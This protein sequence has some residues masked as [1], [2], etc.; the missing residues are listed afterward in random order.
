MKQSEVN[1]MFVEAT[2]SLANDKS[3]ARSDVQIEAE[4]KSNKLALVIILA[5]GVFYLV[6]IREGH[7]WGDDFSMYIQHAKNIAEGA[8]Y[9]LT[10][11]IYCPPYIGPDSY[12]PVYPLLLAPVV[13]LLGMNLTAMKVELVLLF[14]LALFVMVQLVRNYIPVNWQIALIAL[15]GLN[16]YFWE[17]KD[18]IKSEIPFFVAAYLSIYLVHKSYDA[19]EAGATNW[20][21]LGY[22]LATGAAFYLAYGTRSIGLI[23]LPCLGLYDL[24]RKRKFGLPSAYA[25]GVV[26]LTI[27]MI[28]VQYFLLRS[29]RAYVELVQ[30]ESQSFLRDWMRFILMNIPRYATSMTQIWD[31][32]YSK[33]LRVGLTLVMYGLAA[34]GFWAQFRKKVTFIELFVTLYT[35]FVLIIPMDGGVRYLLP[36]VPFYMFYSL[37]G[38]RALPQHRGFR[39][40]AFAAVT[41]AVLVTYVS[42]YTT[43]NFKE[44]PNGITKQEAVEFFDYI[45]RQTGENDVVIFTKP[46][47][48][49]LYTGRKSSYYPGLLGDKGIWD[50][51]QRIKATH[52][53]L[54]PAGVEPQDQVFLSEF[55]SKYRNCVREEYSNG[56]FSVYR[57][58]ALPSPE[59]LSNSEAR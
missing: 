18:H 58:T 41:A 39:N 56:A 20:V 51:F 30:A 17:Y 44:I 35:V 43:Y 7:Y 16:P 22:V 37:Q 40:A 25:V 9:N 12:P 53:V 38:L 45:K 5:I 3:E 6:T 47:A 13:G 52:I 34:I 23:L 14:M 11:Y 10:S 57:I 55:L 59:Q 49:A 4:A 15:V 29:D 1:T 28:V 26:A 36:V 33:L 21:K 19:I 2:A 31:N 27:A 54:G 50:Y 8:P 48:L 42:G 46:R 32:G 24:V